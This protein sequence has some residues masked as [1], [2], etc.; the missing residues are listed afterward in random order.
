MLKLFKKNYLNKKIKNLV[1]K[2][3]KLLISFV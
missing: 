3:Y 1:K 2:N